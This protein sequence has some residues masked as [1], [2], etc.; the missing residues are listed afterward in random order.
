MNNTPNSETNQNLEEDLL[1]EYN[2]D[3]TKAHPNR[4][5]TQINETKIT[6][7]LES[8]VAKVFKTSE[9]VNKA[10]RAIISAIPQQ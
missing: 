5:A 3:Y 7:T 6:V 2:F 9:D 10:L 8:D 1:S 4:F